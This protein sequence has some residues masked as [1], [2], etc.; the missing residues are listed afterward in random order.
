M[1][2]ARILV[3]A[4]P[5][6]DDDVPIN[7]L[8]QL[9]NQSLGDETTYT[10]AI[11]DQP[12]GTTDA[13][14][15]TTI[16]N[17]AFT[18]K[19][20]GSYLVKLIVDLGLP[21]E[22]SDSVIVAV[23][24]MKTLERIPASGETVQDDTA[25]G[26]A[27]SMNSL[28]RRIDNLLSDPGI[29]V[30]VA[31]MGGLIR[32]NVLRVTGGA[33][34]K[35]G[36]P[37]QETVPSFVLCQAS[38]LGSVDELLCVLE[39]G[40]DGSTSPASGALIKVRYIGRIASISMGAGA[41]GDP[42]FVSNAGF[43]EATPGS[44][45]RQIGSIMSVS[46]PNRDIWFDGVGGADI[47]PIDRA[48]VLYGAPSSGMLNAYRIDGSSATGATGGVSPTFKA[49]DA[50]TVALTAKAWS[51]GT[52]NILNVQTSA[53]A[54][55][56]YFDHSGNL[57]F[58]SG[59]DLYFLDS[60]GRLR[61]TNQRI[62]EDTGDT[63]N[64]NIGGAALPG[65]TQ[66]YSNGSTLTAFS[67]LSDALADANTS[68]GSLVAFRGY[69]SIQLL[70]GPGN[71]LE[72]GTNF[73]RQWRLGLDGFW[74]PLTNTYGL[75]WYS[76]P[77]QWTLAPVSATSFYLKHLAMTETFHWFC[78]AAGT[79]TSYFKITNPA[80]TRSLFLEVSDAAGAQ[81]NATGTGATLALGVVSA[82]NAWTI[83]TTGALTATGAR[84][85]VKNLADAGLTPYTTYDALS[86]G[87]Q[88]SLTKSIRRESFTSVPPTSPA[89]CWASPSKNYPTDLAWEAGSTSGVIYPSV[90]CNYAH[91]PSVMAHSTAASMGLVV[92]VTSPSRV[93]FSFR[94]TSED[95]ADLFRFYINGSEK[96]C[97][98]GGGTGA[99]TGH[100]QGGM[101]VSDVLQPGWYEFDWRFTKDGSTTEPGEEC[102]VTDFSIVPEA[103]MQ[104]RS[105]YVGL[106]WQA[107]AF[108]LNTATVWTTVLS[109]CTLARVDPYYDNLY[110]TGGAGGSGEMQWNTYP[111]ASGQDT[112]VNAG[113]F[114]ECVV[115]CY[116]IS[117]TTNCRICVTDTDGTSGNFAAFDV[118]SVGSGITV[119]GPTS[120]VHPFVPALLGDTGEIT[121]RITMNRAGILV[122]VNGVAIQASSGDHPSVWAGVSGADISSYSPMRP[123]F[124]VSSSGAT[125]PSFRIYSFQ[126]RQRM[127]TT[128]V[129]SSKYAGI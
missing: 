93:C 98:S 14:T 16:K 15:S 88:T 78:D 60:S 70:A 123:V 71:V 77:V 122:L 120:Y 65:A 83:A 86:L 110:I 75:K 55:L 24:Q 30:G 11:L 44:Y 21:T 72:L 8:V 117:A 58:A 57:K 36:L 82:P 129:V 6:S 109:S 42:V 92:E 62:G 13:L 10:W 96:L 106:D 127:V 51:S 124:R 5:G 116:D 59:S 23:R 49:G 99:G 73:A 112:D 31:G 94:V 79:A 125:N 114:L 95:Y 19:K 63:D 115:R 25:D 26:W 128:K 50:S 43:I 101:F 27:T 12:P 91:R 34:I 46:G 4:S 32:G 113:W 41:V 40:V 29:I 64:F 97:C 119:T 68:S 37:G 1:P 18:P 76:S 107:C 105:R 126:G 67:I 39:S 28:L 118:N 45:R 35:A 56:A 7:V 100:T 121:V 52:E 80:E 3:N 17:P 33:I 47:T 87:Q 102:A 84:R 20:E 104:D 38:S 90:A 2:Q 66:C 22:Q 9:D 54:N 85:Q 108:P 74:T 103:E 69:A 48:Y 61:W 89:G 53:G 81:I 111:L